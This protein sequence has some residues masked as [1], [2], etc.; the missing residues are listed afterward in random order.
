MDDCT[1]QPRT[2]VRKHTTQTTLQSELPAPPHPPA[3][4]SPLEAYG[5]PQ[6]LPRVSQVLG[7]LIQACNSSYGYSRLTSAAGRWVILS[8]INKLV[9]GQVHA[10]PPTAT[11]TSPR[12][13]AGGRKYVASTVLC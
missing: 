4:H 10:T 7:R 9:T 6:L 1:A 2:T 11:P 13:P 12:R 5:V 3:G 8:N